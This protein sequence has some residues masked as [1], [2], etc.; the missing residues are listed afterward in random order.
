[1]RFL[2]LALSTFCL[3]Q[4]AWSQPQ[5]PVY[6][7]Y[8]QNY[9]QQTASEGAKA[10]E[11]KKVEAA[12]AVSTEVAP[13]Q[14]IPEQKMTPSE[15]E[16]VM[17]LVDFF[18]FK[19]VDYT[20][21][22]E[23][24]T[25]MRKLNEF[26]SSG[27]GV[28][29]GINIGRFLLS[30]LFLNHSLQA[31]YVPTTGFYSQGFN[32]VREEYQGLLPGGKLT[33]GVELIPITRNFVLMVGASGTVFKGNLDNKRFKDEK[34]D[35]MHTRFEGLAGLQWKRGHFKTSVTYGIG[36]GR[37]HFKNPTESTMAYS[38]HGGQW[39]QWEER[40]KNNGKKTER[41]IQDYLNLGLAY[42]F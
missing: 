32:I 28:G 13:S 18:K 20:F 17:T 35:Y 2:F 14:V 12:A 31:G 8:F 37:N 21:L 41:F 29:L 7:F 22:S 36:E 23:A 25:S 38:Q 9:P 5:G 33:L 1:M 26:R 4:L 42:V 11:V 39:N 16:N 40:L 30:G 10:A 34:L 6:N 19:K 27:A 3:G 24:G 15:E